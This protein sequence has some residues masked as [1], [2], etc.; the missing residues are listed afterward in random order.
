MS[1]SFVRRCEDF[2][3]EHCGKTV[4][5]SGYTNHCPSCLWSKHVDVSPGDRGS[6][7]KGMMEPIRIE[8]KKGQYI[9]VHS[10]TLCGCVKRNKAA[11]N[12]N[13]ETILQIAQSQVRRC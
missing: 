1:K 13:F 8:T 4:T 2:T 12:D 6:T 11:Q 5:G 3:C 10:C 7:C 9:I